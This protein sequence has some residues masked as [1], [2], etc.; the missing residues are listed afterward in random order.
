V[1]EI[2]EMNASRTRRRGTIRGLHY[3]QAPYEEAKFVRCT[4]GALY[5]VILDLRPDS[6]T[7]YRWVGLELSAM[8]DRTVYI[9][10]GCAHG[11]QTL[12]DDTEMTYA[13][14]EFYHPEVERGV[15]WNDPAFGI[16]WPIAEVILS[17]KD[18]NLP[19]FSPQLNDG[20]L[21]LETAP[22]AVTAVNIQH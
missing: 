15:R 1:A 10:A 7:R 14:S 8:A 21:P 20:I 19:L 11:F 12:E 9:P 2:V 5:D 6:P 16:T 18:L 22:F 4:R 13:V 17:E 3:Q